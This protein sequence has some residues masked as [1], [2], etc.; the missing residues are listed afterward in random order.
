MRWLNITH[1]PIGIRREHTLQLRR[2]FYQFSCTFAIVFA[3][4][5]E[6]IYTFSHP[7]N[8]V[9]QKTHAFECYQNETNSFS[10][11]TQF[12]VKWENICV[13]LVIPACGL[14]EQ[15]EVDFYR[16]SS[17]SSIC[18][19]AYLDSS[20]RPL[21]QTSML[22]LKAHQNN[23]AFYLETKTAKNRG[24]TFIF[25]LFYA[26]TSKWQNEWPATGSNAFQTFLAIFPLSLE[27]ILSKLLL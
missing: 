23:C 16:L 1:I 22:M 9:L 11:Q 17:N 24:K 12:T 21:S 18:M 19:H 5:V 3:I 8:V 14:L 27:R 6:K 15:S 4:G 10:T 25:Q 2:W 26:P 13:R 7:N 20:I